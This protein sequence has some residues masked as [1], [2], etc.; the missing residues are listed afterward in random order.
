M[1]NEAD[2]QS[3]LADLNANLSAPWVINDGKLHKSFVFQNFVEAFGFM[4]RVALHAEAMNHHPEW[5]N[6]YKTVT[7]DLTTH[8]AGGIS[9][10]D[11]Q[12]AAQIES[13]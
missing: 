11:F 13:M 1:L 7:I 4:L 8:E 3:Q 2:I 6:V 5:F 12:L 9:E 10:L